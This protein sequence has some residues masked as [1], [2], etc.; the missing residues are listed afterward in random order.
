LQKP[1]QFLAQFTDPAGEW[2]PLC[3]LKVT[4]EIKVYSLMTFDPKRNLFSI[5]PLVHSWSQTTITDQQSYH[6]IM[7]A[8]M[9]MSIMEIPYD[10]QKL[11]S[12]S[13]ISH[14]NFLRHV[15][16]DVT[17]DFG[18]QY[19]MVYYY[20]GRYE[21][22]KELYLP[23]LEQRKH[24]L[25]DDHP[26][27]LTVMEYL[28]LTYEGLGQY[29]QAEELQVVVLEKQKRVHDDD[30]PYTLRAMANLASSYGHLG[31]FHTAAE[32]GVV[33]LEKQKQVFGG[34]HPD[35]LLAMG[36]LAET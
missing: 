12:L 29:K 18:V 27:S 13:L 36:N 14:I 34:D 31:R 15:K 7:A 25:S 11:A 16:R 17:V 28:A 9:G 20:A 22:A 3:F 24:L 35:T 30:H 33:V 5:H 23:V 2:D 8:I 19:G 6:S 26:D 4:N 1:L 10:H 32:L 21:E